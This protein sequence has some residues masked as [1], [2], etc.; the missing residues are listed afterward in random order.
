[1]PVGPQ[2][3]HEVK[4]DGYRV[5]VRRDGARVRLF[6]RNGADWSHRFP[7]IVEAVGRL[8]VH[9]AA[10]DGE[11][12]V[13]REGGASDFARPHTQEW[14][15]HVFLYALD[16]LQLNGENLRQEPLEPR[17]A[18]LAKLLAKGRAGHPLQPAHRPGRRARLRACVQA[19]P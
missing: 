10:I 16:L 11:A 19:R 1:V 7:R 2:W 9:S 17:K 14:D 5:I 12:V 6:T 3:V 4:H 13:C 15:D 8:A 18:Q